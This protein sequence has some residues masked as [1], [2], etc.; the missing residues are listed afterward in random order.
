MEQK[1]F[2][3]ARKSTD[4]DDKQA[5]SIEAQLTELKAFAKKENLFI[6]KIIIEK[7]TAKVPGRPLFNDMLNRIEKGEAEGILS[8]HPDRLARNSVDGGRIIYFLDTGKLSALKFP[9][10]WY[11]NTAQGKFMLNMAF[12]QSKYYIDS[13]SEN[14][15]RGLRQKVRNGIYPSLAPIGYINDVRKKMIMVDRKRSIIVR[16]AFELYAK[17]NSGLWDISNFFASQ[18]IFSSGGKHLNGKVC[19]GNKPFKLDRITFILS[20]PFYYGHFRYGKEVFEGKHPPIITK[21]LFDQVQAILK[22]RSRPQYS[23]KNDPEALCGLIRCANCGMGITAEY[24]IKKQKNGNEHH[25]T[26][27]HCTRKNKAIKCSE[28]CIRE[29]VL[30]GQLSSLIENFSLPEDWAQRMFTMLEKDEKD[31]A[32][33]S[34]VFVQESKEKTGVLSQ[35]LQRLLDSYLEQDIER[36]VYLK[37]KA[38]LMSEKKSLEERIITLEQQKTGWIEPLRE[39]VKEAQTG[40]KIARGYDLISKKVIAKKLFG[41]NLLLSSQNL[42]LLPTKIEGKKSVSVSPIVGEKCVVSPGN[43]LVQF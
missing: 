39:W 42:R 36:E 31:G 10:F 35:K 18:G 33:F 9:Q 2:L 40:V 30:D 37:K 27:Y 38:E 15:K 13:L 4:V 12:G 21:N 19:E 28:S 41:S 11:E 14:V 5:L 22:M 1:F 32:H 24:K 16:G 17:G 34:A 23:P 29:E 6:S 8:W 25:Y 20:N 7:K 43:L 3:Y 26:Y